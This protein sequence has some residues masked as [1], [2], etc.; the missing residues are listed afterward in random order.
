MVNLYTLLCSMLIAECTGF[1]SSLLQH[2][3]NLRPDARRRTTSFLRMA[4]ADIA[5]EAAIGGRSYADAVA[6][7]SG[8]AEKFD[9]KTLLRVPWSK[10]GGFKLPEGSK[11]E[12]KAAVASA[13]PQQ[14]S[15][16]RD[17]G[18][19]SISF[20]LAG[21][22]LTS[23]VCKDEEQLFMSKKAVFVHGKT[24]IRGGI[25]ICWPAFNDRNLPA[26]KHGIV[27]T[28]EKWVVEALG[29]EGKNPYVVLTHPTVFFEVDS[30]TKAITG[31]HFEPPSQAAVP[32]SLSLKF[33]L[34]P[35]TLRLE[36]SVQ[37]DGS[38]AFAFSTVLHSYFAVNKMPVTVKGLQGLSG[39]LDG[40]P[41][42]DKEPAVAVT[43][44]TETQRLYTGVHSSVTWETAAAS[45]SSSNKR[46]TVNINPF[47]SYIGLMQSLEQVA[48]TDDQW[49]A[50]GCCCFVVVESC[51]SSKSP[52][53]S[54]TSSSGTLAPKMPQPWRMWRRAATSA[55]YA[56]KVACAR[57]RKLL[58]RRASVG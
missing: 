53:I 23:W 58:S 17:D 38:S 39:F 3:A 31:Y 49:C 48:Q 19:A 57:P 34:M 16:K 42:T 51:C 52:T 54:Q 35:S 14:L 10:T 41:F 4:A 56:S 21:G 32:A 28:S 29:M 5:R 26:G 8:G 36:M 30:T 22:H 44:A 43:G 15:L 50:C 33:S 6:A 7:A 12:P 47:H 20:C 2:Q 46:L 40:K 27:R 37:N 1:Q 18:L 45:S 24:A 25:P 13:L 9:P 55:I 11:S